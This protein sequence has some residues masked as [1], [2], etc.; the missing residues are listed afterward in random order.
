MRYINRYILVFILIF[1]VS[2]SADANEVMRGTCIRVLDGDTVDIVSDGEHELFRVR[3]W[4]I[5]AP[6]TSQPYGLAARR[7]LAD[8]I[9]GKDVQVR[10]LSVDLYGR[11][12][13]EV[14]QNSQNVNEYM[15]RQGLAWYYE[16]YARN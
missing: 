3:L 5:D 7:A 16:R 2:Y 6:E 11:C 9:L 13:G 12:V 1:F 10:I 4:G 15:L 8:V 14:F